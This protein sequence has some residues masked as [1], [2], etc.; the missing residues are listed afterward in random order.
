MEGPAVIAIIERDDDAAVGKIQTVDADQRCKNRIAAFG[1]VLR[2]DFV[3]VAAVFRKVDQDWV[4]RFAV[5]T[6]LRAASLAQAFADLCITRPA[7]RVDEIAEKLLA[8]GDAL[9]RHHGFGIFYRRACTG[10][11][12][13]NKNTKT[14]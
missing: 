11:Y 5:V 2:A 4:Q 10:P 12:T 14:H 9:F 6:E 7:H 3:R 1:D 13:N 8:F